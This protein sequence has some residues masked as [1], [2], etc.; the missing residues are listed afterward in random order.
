MAELFRKVA[1][2]Y[3]EA[4]PTYPPEL[5]QF[6]SSKTPHHDLVWDVGTGSGQA[7]VSLAELYKEVVATDTSPEQLA[8]APKL[9]NIRYVRTPAA[10]SLDGLQRDVAPPSTVDLITV[11]QALHWFHLPT[12]YA[13]ARNLLRGPHGVLAAWCYT[14]PRVNAA[15]DS[16]LGRVYTEAGPFWAPER[17]TVEDELRNID[18]PFDPVDGEEHTGPFEFS[19]ESKMDLE[20]YLT[21]IRSWSAYQT[22]REKGLELLSDGVISD[23]ERAW[24]GDG[25]AVK[26]L[27][28]PIFLRIGK[29]RAH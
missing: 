26:V 3:A 12:F 20:A 5:F 25:A 2:K 19:A 9:P 18:F 8:F 17:R 29:V 22:A 24:G 6:I 13:Q 28:Y 11:A 23:L 14:V 16:I 4:R 15:V 27:R 21:Y 7:A 1:K 10:V